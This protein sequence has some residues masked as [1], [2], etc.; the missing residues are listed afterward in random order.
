MLEVQ[1]SRAEQ[2]VQIAAE[3]IEVERLKGNV[4]KRVV[5]KLKASRLTL[6]SMYNDEDFRE[7][8][9]KT[10]EVVDNM[11]K[12]ISTKEQRFLDVA[13]AAHKESDVLIYKLIAKRGE[14]LSPTT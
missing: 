11:L 13:I 1:L 8:A 5:R 14:D 2:L 7:I 10:L 6:K 12:Y 3:Y 4:S 9:V